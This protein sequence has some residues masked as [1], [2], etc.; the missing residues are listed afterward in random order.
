MKNLLHIFRFEWKNLWRSHTLMILMLVFLGAGVYGIYFVMF[1]I[2]KQEARMASVQEYE[3][4]QFDSLT[5]WVALD[6]SIKANK[7]KF[8][9]AVSPTG[10][11]RSR[12][13]TYYVLHHT[14]PLAGLC[15]GQRD[16][17]PVYYGLNVTDLARQMNIGE[18]ANPMKL[19]TGNFDLSYV[20]VFLLPLLIVAFFYDLYSMERERGTLTLLQS[21]SV[22]LSTVL[23]GK[24]VL[25][26]LI[27][28]GLATGLFLLG[29]L[30]QGIS[31]IDHS[32][33]LFQ[34][35]GLTYAY[36]LFWAA[37]M[38]G[39]VALR[40]SSATSAIYGLGIWLIL[41]II[42]PALLNLFA[43][44]K[45]PLPKRSESVHALRTLN[46]KVWESPRSFVF[47]QFYPK[48]PQYDQGDTTNFNKWYY[49]GFTLF[50]EKTQS[51]N[52]EYEKQV[53]KRN[54]LLKDWQWLA[55][56]AMVHENFSSISKTDRESHLRFVKKVQEF[57]DD[58]KTIYYPKIFEEEH[59]S[60]T[61]LMGL[62]AK[63][64]D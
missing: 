60:K 58:L 59:F 45:T 27:V 32:A 16:L 62:Q 15:L 4:S 21:Q 28:L 19:L 50:D 20:I 36:C 40:R 38:T 53:A 49:A 9:K 63:L 5:T 14:P 34:S 17:F 47:D 56:A 10:E 43:L 24:G 13:F 22:K 35:L 1:E 44:T 29:F 39:V 61:D 31:L 37:V 42:S 55:P 48:N 25:R 11:G 54:Q 23:I 12:H 64:D 46:D 26:L 6:T 51:L 8:Q 33:L 30:L 7:V 3:R 41:T 18:L 2:E 52:Q 57:H